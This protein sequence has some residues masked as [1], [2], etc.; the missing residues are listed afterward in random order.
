MKPFAPCHQAPQFVG[1]HRH[2][3][4]LIVTLSLMI[5]L[6]VIAVGLLSIASI[7]LRASGQSTAVSAARANARM[8]LLLAVGDLQK[9]AGKDTRITARADLTK[10]NLPPILG[11]WKSWEGSDHETSGTFQGRPVAPDYVGGKSKRFLGWLDS[12]SSAANERDVSS[13]PDASLAEGKVNLFGGNTVSGG[14]N[15]AIHLSSTPLSGPGLKGTFAWWVSGENQKARLPSPQDPVSDT[16]VGWASAAK[17]HQTTDPQPFGLDSLLDDPSVQDPSLTSPAAKALSLGQVAL[18][19]S[20]PT[21]PDPRQY[22]HDLSTTSVG[23]LTN[24]ATGGWRKDLTL[25]AENWETLPSSGLPYFRLTPEQ[26]VA[27]TRATSQ[28]PYIARSVVY[29]WSDYRGG[30]SAY[31]PIYRFPAISSWSNLINYVNLYKEMPSTGPS[32]T[33]ALDARAVSII[34]DTFDFTHKVRLLPAVARVQWIFAH[35]SKPSKSVARKYDLD[36][37]VNPVITLWNPYNVTIR[38]TGALNLDLYGTLPPAID[39]KIDGSSLGK[40][41][42]LKDDSGGGYG[43]TSFSKDKGIVG[44]GGG[45]SRHTVKDSITLAPGETRVFS[46]KSVSPIGAVLELMAGYNPT[47]GMTYPVALGV[48]AETSPGRSMI[49]TEMTFDSEFFDGPGGPEGV[50]VNINMFMGNAWVLAYR[51]K[52]ERAMAN[53][54]YPPIGSQK[55]PSVSLAQASSVAAPFLSITFGARMASNTHLSSKGFVQSSPFVN[56]TAMGIRA[57]RE[58]TVQYDYPGARH[59]VNSPFEFSFQGLTAGS[60]FTPNVDPGSGRGYIMTGFQAA[61]GLSRCVI[62]ELPTRPLASLAEL[63]NWDARYEN[64]VPPFAFNLVANS[65]AS[66]LI[67]QGTASNTSAEAAKGGQN[68]QHDDS[69]CLNHLLFDDWFVSSLAPEPAAFGKP[70]PGTS[71]KKRWTEFL[72]DPSRPL[73]NRAYHPLTADQA[74]PDSSFEKHVATEGSWKTIASRFEVVG[75]FNVNST[76][77][78]AWRALLGHSRNQKTA[79]L[80]SSSR[81]QLSNRADFAFS[82]FSV[83]GDVEASRAGSSGA[84]ADCAEYAGYRQFDEEQLDFLAKEIVKQVRLRGPFLSLSEFVNRQLSSNQDLALA[85]TIQTALNNLSA[86]GLDPFRTLKINLTPETPNVS[87]ATIPNSGYQFPKAAEGYNLYGIP[88]WTRQAD[89]LRPLAPVLTVRDDTFTIRAYGDVRDATG[90]KIIASAICE[91]TVRRTRD[92]VDPSDDSATADLSNSSGSV[93][94]KK[95]VNETFGRRFEIVSF[96]WLNPSEV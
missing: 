5:L 36:V 93:A 19:S 6:V 7:S 83:A 15:P 37:I 9:H 59:N 23:L 4:A 20:N 21:A 63:Q 81:P 49:S 45:N 16:T 31:D 68:L 43:L 62:S 56:F 53:V 33:P 54:F 78:K 76:S 42:T 18:I 50:G 70:S 55:F 88:G 11:V 79:H 38:T 27:G 48:G 8:A 25:A 95:P 94:R 87:T 74:D 47:Y 51:M 29:P 17:S 67:P 44:L 14:G 39:Y 22:F 28:A 80:D 90:K 60:T 35:K 41:F 96:R 73:A 58:S 91:A 66:P 57:A 40:R 26:D 86:S 46:A 64:P 71:L 24:S 30:G 34:G 12:V 13:P 82:R 92:F 10:P 61:D 69:Y 75:M 32:Q 77:E 85:G 3:F 65:D 52:Y 89:V 84:K 1:T 2:G 72:N